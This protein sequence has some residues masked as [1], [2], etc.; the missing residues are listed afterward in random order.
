MKILLVTDD[1][2]PNLGGVSHTLMNLYKHIDNKGH[3]LYIFNPYYVNKNIFKTITFLENYTFRDLLISIWKRK[4]HLLMLNSFLKIIKDNSIL[5]SHRLRIILH[6][7]IK[8][9]ILIWVFENI[10][11]MYPLLK[12][13]EFD[14]IM[15]GNSYHILDLNFVLSRLFQKKI[16]AMAH[17]DDFLIPSSIIFKSLYSK[18]LYFK[19]ADKIILSN[20]ITKKLIKKIHHLNEEKLEVI[21]RA[22]NL[23][24]L[25][26]SKTKSELR[27]EFKISEELFILL[28]VGVQRIIKRFD[29][30]IQAVKRIKE[31]NPKLRIKYILIGDG[32]QN[33]YLKRLSKD[34]KLEN[35]VEF[36]GKCDMKKRNKYYK[37]SDAFVMPSMSTKSNIEGF[38]ITFIEANYY[39]LPVIGTRSG[40]IPSVIKDGVNGLLIEQNN[41][42]ALV[43]KILF[44]YN[45][46]ELRKQMGE[47]GHKRIIEHYTW[48]KIIYDYI[49]VFKSVL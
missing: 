23:P 24:D 6:F 38:G 19:Y 7:L 16:I 1:F 14:I 11:I 43:E 36:L 29:L 5:F 15:G 37:L 35:E 4:S 13:R 3:T 39:K 47:N 45:H 25:E 12:K 9:R 41:I 32:E 27:R 33:S 34:L 8:P 20:N 48:D 46:E 28:S 40:G 44:L 30:V 10:L 42:N 31:E 2:Y 18:S 26:I 22:L 17:G 49:K 21:N